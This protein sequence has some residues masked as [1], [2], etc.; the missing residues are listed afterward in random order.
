MNPPH[1]APLLTALV[2]DS[3]PDRELVRVGSKSLTRSQLL[4]ASS[5]LAH[6]VT[7]AGVVAIHATASLET[8]V[9]VVGCL[10][11]GTP[12]VPLPPDA[13]PTER[14]H[15]LQH[16]R[17][18]LLIGDGAHEADPPISTLS[19]DV[20]ART[21]SG[22]TP[23]SPD[24]HTT[25][26]LMYT[27]GTTGLPKGVVLSHAAIA[28]GVDG[29][30]DAWAWDADDVLV[31]GLPLFH[32]H[33]LLLGV[34]GALRVGSP[35]VH[36]VRPRPELYAAAAGS[37]YFGVPTVWSRVCADSSA[38]RQLG[39]ARLLVS[40]SAPLPIPVFEQ[41]TAITG[42]SP[43]ER[44]GMSET[45]ITLSTRHDSD[46]RPGWVGVPVAGVQ[47][48]LRDDAGQPVPPDGETFG[49]LQVTGTTMFDGY[50]HDP[51]TS[52]SAHTDDGFFRTGDVA[53]VDPSGD[54]RIVGRES[55]D[56]IKSGGYRIGA[57]EVEQ[58]FLSH[59][60]VHEVAV[61]GVPDS[62][63]GQRLVAFVVGHEVDVA[64]LSDSVAGCL[65]SHKRPREIR[66]LEALPRNAMGKIQKRLLMDDG[67]RPGP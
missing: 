18:T 20:R 54:H 5:A 36:T 55:V 42:R 56:L 16:S 53:V 34:V 63:L 11:A 29:L 24:P 31:H 32:V 27:S 4:A 61:V 2:D 14:S 7:G 40:G 49:N 1:P 33:G 21:P 50:L 52:D 22:P 46:R 15:I 6:D 35:L 26:C 19:V 30:A 25:A 41:M 43:V 23:P 9:G 39:T 17:A 57:G 67:E 13:G 64:A 47:T 10:L 38:A 45:L 37:L 44:Y 62:D 51:E 3:Q 65:T 59:P 28:A 48:R 8:L 58:A 12:F 66:V 60:S